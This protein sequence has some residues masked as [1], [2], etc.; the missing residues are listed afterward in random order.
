MI[1]SDVESFGF[2]QLQW[3]TTNLLYFILDPEAFGYL[4]RY[5]QKEFAVENMEF[6]SEVWKFKSMCDLF[7]YK[8]R[9]VKALVYEIYSNFIASNAQ[10]ALNLSHNRIANITE[11]VEKRHI[12]RDMFDVAE[13]EILRLIAHDTFVRFKRTSEYEQFS[14]NKP[15]KFF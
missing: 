6:I 15:Y 3:R 4:Y 11:H 2:V 9:R 8:D 1:S 13:S 12:Q 7:G 10:M 14:K 5:C